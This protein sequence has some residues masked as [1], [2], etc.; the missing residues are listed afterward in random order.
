MHFSPLQFRIRFL[1]PATKLR[2][3]N[4][5][6]LVRH[7]VHGGLCRGGGSLCSGLC[8]V[9]YIKV[10]RVCNLVSSHLINEYIKDPDHTSSTHPT[11]TTLFGW[12]LLLT[13][14]SL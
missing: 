3:G 13:I 2:Q 11:H 5:F 1:P 9:L 10:N 6:T 12:K 8:L 4:V 7:S 14:M